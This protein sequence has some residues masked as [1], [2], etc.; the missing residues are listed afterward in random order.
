MD[1]KPSNICIDQNGDFVLIDFGSAAKFN[2]ISESTAAYVPHKFTPN[3]SRPAVDWW[4]LAATLSE[5]AGKCDRWGKGISNPTREET[6][7]TLIAYPAI[8]SE[9]QLYLTE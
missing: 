2:N 9:L 8:V 3:P 5:K 1:V 7:A 4:M 6:L